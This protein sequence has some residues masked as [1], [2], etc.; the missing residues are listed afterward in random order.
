MFRRIGI[1]ILLLAIAVT[2]VYG[3][4]NYLANVRIGILQNQKTEVERMLEEYSNSLT[5]TKEELNI[6]IT[7]RQELVTTVNNY[8]TEVTELKSQA[9]I[10]TEKLATAEANLATAEQALED[11]D[12][13]IAKLKQDLETF[14]AICL[15]ANFSRETAIKAESF[16]FTY[17][18]FPNAYFVD[19]SLN[20][21]AWSN[22]AVSGQ[23]DFDMSTYY[24][25]ALSAN[26]IL[27]SIGINLSTLNAIFAPTVS[28]CESFY[29]QGIEYVT[30]DIGCDW[31]SNSHGGYSNIFKIDLFL[32]QVD[33]GVI[34]SSN[35]LDFFIA[36][37]TFNPNK[38]NESLFNKLNA[39]EVTYNS[40]I[41]S[42]LHLHGIIPRAMTDDLSEFTTINVPFLSSSYDIPLKIQY[43]YLSPFKLVFD[44]NFLGNKAI[45]CADNYDI[46]IDKRFDAVCLPDYWLSNAV[47]NANDDN[48][49]FTENGYIERLYLPRDIDIANMRDDFKSNIGEVVFLPFT[50]MQLDFIAMALMQG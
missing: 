25:P 11:K 29:N 48:F 4:T 7:E 2:G 23:L 45:I 47:I 9:I 22:F 6:A 13:E 35:W 21:D 41:I 18:S 16:D 42:G 40:S 27:K 24:F 17:E 39:G 14:E 10:D 28:I 12:A 37:N 5:V 44:K 49:S 1:F 36:G 32:E 46:V 30:L 19:S 50:Q 20:N 43:R 31:T 3:I 38:T 26:N 15:I 34:D 8:Q 33:S